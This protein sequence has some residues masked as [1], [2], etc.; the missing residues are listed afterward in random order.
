MMATAQNV[1]EIAKAE[2]GYSAASDP[3]PGSKYGRWMAGLTGE[4]W[5]AGPS[6]S[7]WWC[8]MFV[9]WCLD[10]AGQ[11]CTG[12]PSYNTD[13]VLG[14]GPRLVLREDALPGDIIIW[15][16]DGNGATDHIGIVAEHEPGA[17]G[18]LVTVEGNYN[19]TVSI[20]D[21]S[22]VW[23]LVSA[24]IR[25]PYDECAP[26]P[27]PEHI[28]GAADVPV[29]HW[30]SWYVAVALGGGWMTGADGYWRPDDPIS[31]A[32]AACAL[33]KREGSPEASVYADLEDRW[34][35]EAVEWAADR[36]IASVENAAFRPMDACTRAEAATLVARYAGHIADT[37]AEGVAIASEQGWMDG[38]RLGEPCTRAEFAAMVCRATE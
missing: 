21:R 22:G 27:E 31:R 4:S 12:F 11:A 9:S 14:R 26:E 36:G 17:L 13:L 35:R 33:W 3:D 2:V 10:Q 34:Y 19:N 32:E 7:I 24:V 15:D 38:T 23:G 18:R 1:L 20:V 25:P 28:E 37:V 16:W 8:C 5:L 29:Q 30:A 6:T